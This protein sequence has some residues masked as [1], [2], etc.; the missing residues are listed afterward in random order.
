M[1][2]ERF[3]VHIGDNLPILKTL[4]DNSVDAIVTDPFTGSGTTGCAATL[5][6]FG[7]IGIER[8]AEYAEIAR[9]RIEYWAGE[10]SEP[11][12]EPPLPLFEVLENQSE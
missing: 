6:G 10:A 11:V 3:T 1:G 12:G 2:N 5:E 9:R 4:A 8:E 7:F